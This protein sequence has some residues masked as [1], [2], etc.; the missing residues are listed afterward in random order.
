M[1]LAAAQAMDDLAEALEQEA[2]ELPPGMAFAAISA[3]ARAHRKTAAKIRERAQ[4][5]IGGPLPVPD[6]YKA[7]NGAGQRRDR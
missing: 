6:E 3:M 4:R 7:G 5:E 2:E 1:S